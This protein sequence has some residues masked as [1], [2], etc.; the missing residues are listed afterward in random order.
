MLTLKFGHNWALS[1]AVIR[2]YDGVQVLG[3]EACYVYTPF[4]FFSTKFLFT[5]TP[6]D[7]K[8]KPLTLT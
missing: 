3:S 1:L 2:I 5:Y 8:R 6:V 7:L 4:F